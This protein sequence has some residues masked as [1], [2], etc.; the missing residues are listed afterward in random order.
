MRTHPIVEYYQ[1]LRDSAPCLSRAATLPKSTKLGLGKRRAPGIPS[2]RNSHT[3]FSPKIYNIQ[4]HLA[5]A[6][7]LIRFFSPTYDDVH[8][9]HALASSNTCFTLQTQ[10]SLK[11]PFVWFVMSPINHPHITFAYDTELAGTKI[12][13]RILR[14][15]RFYS[16]HGPSI[17]KPGHSHS[18]GHQRF[19]AFSY[20]KSHPAS[21]PTDGWRPY[22]KSRAVT[23]GTSWFTMPSLSSYVPNLSSHVPKGKTRSTYIYIYIYIIRT[24]M[25]RMTPQH[26][27]F[28]THTKR[29]VTPLKRWARKLF[30]S[31]STLQITAGYVNIPDHKGVTHDTSKLTKISLLSRPIAS[32][33]SPLVCS[34]R[35]STVTNVGSH[36]GT[37][38]VS[39]PPSQTDGVTYHR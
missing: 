27:A 3:G 9:Y 21:S 32:G 7:I 23:S 30:P 11:Q 26:R 1:A 37:L 20:H 35:Q 2:F 24:V 33:R 34:V 15:S 36:A 29:A 12:F 17:Y 22:Y 19:T 5:L 10:L 4:P 39:T 14:K 28:I 13:E 25:F 18:L 31:V 16:H 6:Q 38:Y 8:R